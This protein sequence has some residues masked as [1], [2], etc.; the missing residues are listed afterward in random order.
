MRK[1]S[2]DIIAKLGRLIAKEKG[3]LRQQVESEQLPHVSHH[4]IGLCT[5]YG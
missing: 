2:A 3:D 1:I 4:I 5:E